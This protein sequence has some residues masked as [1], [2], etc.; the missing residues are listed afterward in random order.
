MQSIKRY[1]RDMNEAER[2]I[3]DKVFCI[4]LLERFNLD[5]ATKFLSRR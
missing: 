2:T 5:E 4:A 3:N 1:R